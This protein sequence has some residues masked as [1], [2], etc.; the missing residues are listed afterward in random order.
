M[1][2]FRVWANLLLLM[3]IAIFAAGIAGIAGSS[4]PGAL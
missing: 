2:S 3:V 1:V 4:L